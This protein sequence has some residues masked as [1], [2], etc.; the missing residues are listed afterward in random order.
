MTNQWRK[1]K[2]MEG[3]FALRVAFA[4]LIVLFFSNF[5]WGDLGGFTGKWCQV[6]ADRPGMWGCK[7][8]PDGAWEVCSQDTGGN[9]DIFLVDPDTGDATNLSTHPAYDDGA[10]WAPDSKR[11]VF[12]SDRDGSMDLYVIKVDGTGLTNLTRHAAWDGWP[13]WSPDGERIAFVSDRD[14]QPEI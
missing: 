3:P 10:D 12:V 7:T 9:T 1:S 11:I 5:L 4:S 8:S 14:G 6:H 13:A 2:M